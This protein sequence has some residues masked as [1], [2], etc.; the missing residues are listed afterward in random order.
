MMV[1]PFVAKRLINELWLYLVLLE[2]LID[3][4]I[5]RFEAFH[6]D[7]SDESLDLHGS[8]PRICDNV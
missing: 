6:A 3:V 8:T 2:P 5:H 1:V 4:I 7:F